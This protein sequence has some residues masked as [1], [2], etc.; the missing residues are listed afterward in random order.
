MC[1]RDPVS[2]SL[3]ALADVTRTRKEQFLDLIRGRTSLTC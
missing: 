1:F 2:A 3:N